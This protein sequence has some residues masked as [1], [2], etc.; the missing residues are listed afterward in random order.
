M[1]SVDLVPRIPAVAL[2]L[3]CAAVVPASAQNPDWAQ[4]NS[5]TLRH[6]QALVQIDSTN[7]PGNETRVADYVK[8]VLEAE[9]IPV[10]LAAKDPARANVIARLKGNGSKRPLLIMGH[11]D[12]VKVD[13]P[14]WVFPPFSAHLDGGYVYGR[15]T[16]DDKSDL[17]AALM[18]MLLLKRQGT[19]L[20]RDVIF[21]S[22]VG[23]EASTGPGIEYLVNERWPEI[24]AEICL[25][26]SGGVRRRDGKLVYA[27][28]ETTEKQPKG[29]VLIS[30]GP[31]GHGSRPLRTNAVVHLAKA[32][33]VIAAW[34]PP[35]KFNDTT[36]YYFEKLA[37]VS[38]PQT[39]Q[40]YKDL[41]NPA[42]AAAARDY[43]AEHEP[44][45]YSM[46]H[47]SIS[48]NIIEAGYQVN[49]I[50]S[51]ARATLD[52]RALPGE[53]IDA[54]YAMMRKVIN[55]PAIELVPE[56]RNQRPAA[57]PSS[58][59]NDAYRSVEAAYK[60]IY[61]VQTLPVMSTGATDMA[62]LRAK[63]VQCYGV[64]AMV[65]EEDAA[66]GFGAHSDQE[67]ILEEAIYKHTQFFW[68]AVTS[69]AGKH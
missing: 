22:E 52:I 41:F 54:F 46:L 4:I 19:P 69:I 53:D 3:F 66:K 26:E 7:P 30:K 38:D 58:I 45:L 37:G 50:P 14:K 62:F 20:D 9:G 57:A 34:E 59:S 2:Y 36:R 24:D 39:A 13:P 11:S 23:E 28:V 47:T 42:K 48:P 16:L 51:E 63:G 10:T 43:L 55:D 1:R 40:R 44:G 8:K 32:V 60:K 35:T 27:T 56:T 21:V 25:A 15:G 61:G 6:F 17:A 64:G 31:A 65:D 49:V 68:D 29:A 67:R 12:T 5:E 33:E 18:T